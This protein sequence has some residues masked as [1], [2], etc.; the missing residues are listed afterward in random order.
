MNKSIVFSSVAAAVLGLGLLFFLGRSAA[1]NPSTVKAGGTVFV[2][3]KPKAGVR[4]SP[5]IRN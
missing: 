4:P 1:F 2:G 3:G 5:I